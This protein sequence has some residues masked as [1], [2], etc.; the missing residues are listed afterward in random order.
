VI[1]DIESDLAIKTLAEL[2]I[3]P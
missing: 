2:Q 3:I 1:I